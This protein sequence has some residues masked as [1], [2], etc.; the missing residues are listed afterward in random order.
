MSMILL[1][2]GCHLDHPL[3]QVNQAADHLISWFQQ[4]QTN[5]RKWLANNTARV[6]KIDNRRFRREYG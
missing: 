5:F 3:S 6:D 1:L 4:R 2:K